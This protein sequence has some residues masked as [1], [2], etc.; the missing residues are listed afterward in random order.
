MLKINWLN[1]LWAFYFLGKNDSYRMGYTHDFHIYFLIDFLLR[2]INNIK[3]IICYISLVL[4]IVTLIYELLLFR[5][6]FGLIICWKLKI[7]ADKIDDSSKFKIS[8][9]FC[10]FKSRFGNRVLDL[11]D[12][13]YSHCT[14]KFLIHLLI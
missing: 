9:R 14:W 7:F 2:N 3:F 1:C 12:V 11:K 10:K 5:S 13:L 4:T 8:S 6:I